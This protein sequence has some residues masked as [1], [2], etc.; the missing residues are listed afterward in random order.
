MQRP[1]TDRQF[2][3]RRSRSLDSPTLLSPKTSCLRRDNSPS[4]SDS[5][6][7][8]IF[9]HGVPGQT[10]LVSWELTTTWPLAARPYCTRE[11]CAVD[12]LSPLFINRLW[13]RIFSIQNQTKPNDPRS[14]KINGTKGKCYLSLLSNQLHNMS[15]NGELLEDKVRKRRKTLISQDGEEDTTAEVS[16]GGGN[17]FPN[18]KPHFLS[19][20]LG[21]RG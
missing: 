5:W 17:I 8:Y 19:N 11:R 10:N 16:S 12:I 1:S 4:I 14:I 9:V 20:Y 21:W 6:A 7:Q 3:F 13:V 18:I 2:K 15:E